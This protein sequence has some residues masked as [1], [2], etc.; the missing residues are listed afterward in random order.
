MATIINNP[1]KTDEEQGIGVGFIIGI[2]LAVIIG[3]LLFM[4]GLPM[5]QSSLASEREAQ[6]IIEVQV[7]AEV[8]PTG[9]E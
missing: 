7:P 6:T 5:L 2:I 4:Y 1:P 3:V 9:T 8:T